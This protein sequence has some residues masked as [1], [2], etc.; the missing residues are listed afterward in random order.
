MTNFDE[1]ALPDG[2][3][4]K[5]GMPFSMHDPESVWIVEE[6]QVDLFVVAGPSD[7]FASIAGDESS[8]GP[9][10]GEPGRGASDRGGS[11]R[12]SK[13]S[14]G[15]DSGPGGRW[16][17]VDRLEQGAALWGV[18]G[19]EGVLLICQPLPGARLARR[20]RRELLTAES[21]P[22]LERWL[23]RLAAAMGG[24]RTPGRWTPLTAAGL[25]PDIEGVSRRSGGAPSDPDPG[26]AAKPAPEDDAEGESEAFVPA[27]FLWVEPKAGSAHTGSVRWCGRPDLPLAPGLG[28]VGL[29]M[30]TWLEAT[31]QVPLNARKTAQLLTDPEAAARA[32]DGT[33]RLALRAFAANIAAE[34]R[35]AARRLAHRRRHDRALMED[36]LQRLA[37][38]GGTGAGSS[39]WGDEEETRG[40]GV[41][42]PLFLACRLVGRA[43]GISIKPPPSLLAGRRGRDPVGDIAL[44]SRVQVRPV[45]LRGNWWR[46]DNGPLLGFLDE[47]DELHPVALLPRSPWSYDVVDGRD[48]ARR[49][50]TGAEAEGLHP[51]AFMF[52]PSLPARAVTGLDLLRLGAK[53]V[54]GRDLVV[55]FFM[56]LAVGGLG[57]LMPIVTGDL[58]DRVIPQADTGQIWPLALLLLASAFGSL[59]FEFT[60]SVAML[61][62]EGRL[63]TATQAAVWDRV[64]NLPARFFR[65]HSS[66]DL[67]V[68]AMGINAIRQALSGMA[69]TT[70]LSSV[71]SVF[72]FGLLFYYDRSLAGVA[73]AVLA[74]SVS[75]TSLLG[76][77]GVRFQ[78][79]LTEMQGRISGLVLQI[80]NGINKFRMAGAEKRAFFLW[81]DE[82]SRQ[83]RLAYRARTVQNVQLTVHGVLPVATN[84]VLF[85]AF[86]AGSGGVQG[87]LSTGHFLA[88]MT[89]FGTVNSALMGLSWTLLSL[90]HVVPLYERAKPILEAAPE[91]DPSREDPGE[92]AGEIELS[93]VSFRYEAEAPLVVDGASFHIRPGQFVAIVGPSG[94]GKSTLLRLLLGFE[95]P[96]SG[97]IYFDGKDLATLDLRAVRRQI[98]VVLQNGVLTQGDIYSNIVGAANIGMDEAWEAARMAGLAADI[99]K[100]PMGMHTMIPDG[101]GTL[102]GGQ[103]QRLLIA[104][105]LV[106]KPRILLFDEATSA[107]DNVTQSIVMQSLADLRATRVVVAHRLS[108]V[109]HA[110]R[111][112]VFNRGRVVQ[113]GTYDELVAQEGMFAELARRQLA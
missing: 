42:D 103:R 26:P 46:E 25:D 65:E 98:G 54:W 31:A 30:K 38:V 32:I 106:R 44:A 22:A 49:R 3:P 102:S 23:E 95:T 4:P 16:H 51:Q 11:G 84:L 17:H 41:D 61:R 110:D 34:E 20:S 5:P 83:R 76:Y 24:R 73:T 64:V 78:R 27:E 6:G 18:P 45:R 69:L 93:H 107:L 15:P 101:G 53:A 70:I 2:G 88:F 47:G 94:Q 14:P 39:P 96:Q 82:F 7:V 92:L 33:H 68:R 66:G 100:M 71:F 108:T 81:A 112:F 37:G 109:M 77:L 72:S 63:E 105:A 55:V 74:V 21:A 59:L 89:A 57:M 52:Y 19:D 91:I 35:T 80:V 43:Q 10:L 85:T 87:G 8:S 111:I 48:G 58:F 90:L 56:G 62:V 28:P 113:Q 67:A 29:P 13:S 104:R 97:S 36:A 75:V 99:E 40:A 9:R 79:Q 50:V 12:G 1:M 60:R 86:M